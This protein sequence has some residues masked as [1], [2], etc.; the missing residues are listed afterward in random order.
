MWEVP[1]A[2]RSWRG[3][4]RPWEALAGPLAAPVLLKWLFDNSYAV[5]SKGSGNS[6]DIGP[7]QGRFQLFELL[8]SSINPKRVGMNPAIFKDHDP[9]PA[10][11]D[12]GS[13]AAHRRLSNLRHWHARSTSATSCP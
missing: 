1:E 5:A 3:P 13:D 10:R 12:S 6:P 2:L 4:G 9:C 7:S 11:G 8:C